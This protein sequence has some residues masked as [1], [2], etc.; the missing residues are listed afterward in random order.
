LVG[1][2]AVARVLD[3]LQV[4]ALSG[5]FDAKEHAALWDDTAPLNRFSISHKLVLR[6]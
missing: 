1:A 5:G 6:I 3:D 4:T 2:G